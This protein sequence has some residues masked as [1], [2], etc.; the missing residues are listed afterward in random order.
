MDEKKLEEKTNLFKT[1]LL[2]KL[3]EIK[4]FKLT[5]SPWDTLTEEKFKEFCKILESF[6]QYWK[7]SLKDHSPEETK[8]IIDS[9][10][11]DTFCDVQKRL[12]KGFAALSK[13]RKCLPELYSEKE[14][15]WNNLRSIGDIIGPRLITTTEN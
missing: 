10:E 3:E 15:L 14:E 9:I 7:D 2:E 13:A 6:Y 4:Q 12:I 11:S 8:F 1:G 5:K